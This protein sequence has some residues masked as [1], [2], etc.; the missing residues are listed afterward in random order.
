MAVLSAFCLT[1]L[2]LH[3]IKGAAD[4]Y[5]KV[6]FGPF[7]FEYGARPKVSTDE[8]AV[9][10]KQSAAGEDPPPGSC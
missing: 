10:K 6:K 3:L 4:G 2:A 1:A 7:L 8:P 5:L 9:E